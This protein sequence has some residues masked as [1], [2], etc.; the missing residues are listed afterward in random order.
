MALLS[1]Y[2]PDIVCFEENAECIR[3]T[4]LAIKAKGHEV[5][6]IFRLGYEEFNDGTHWIHFDQSPIVKS[7]Q[8]SLIHADVLVDDPTMLRF[9]E[10]SPPFD[11]VTVWLMGTYM[12]RRTCRNISNLKIADTNEYRLRV[13]NRIYEIANRALRTGGCLQIVD[14][15]EPPSTE[16]LAKDLKDSHLDQARGTDLQVIDL[17]YRIYNE[18]T[19][20]GISMVASIGTSGRIVE[21]KELAM[22]S[23]VSRKMK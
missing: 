10:E 3:K 14:R 22:T 8:V 11:A 23:I 2:D 12:S 5:E 16:A 17:Q 18:P 13:Q 1:A 6:P 4:G 7:S 9:L 15:G 20:R 19:V 21:L